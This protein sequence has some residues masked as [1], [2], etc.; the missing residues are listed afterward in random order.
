MLLKSC[1]ARSVPGLLSVM[2]ACLASASSFCKEEYDF[3][4]Y[5]NSSR[6]RSGHI[7]EI[8]SVGHN[9]GK[10]SSIVRKTGGTCP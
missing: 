7:E 5:C 6:R 9:N 3:G 1:Q 8:Y 2:L 10:I 4:R